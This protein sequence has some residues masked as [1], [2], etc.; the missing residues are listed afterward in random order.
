M[1]R[2]TPLNMPLPG[3]VLCILVLSALFLAIPAANGFPFIFSDTGNYIQS[4]LTGQFR[5]ARSPAYSWFALLAH[6]EVSP[7][8]LVAAQS[9]IV[10]TLNEVGYDG[11]LSVEFCAPIDRTP[12]DP[13]PD[14]LEREPVDISP[15][16]RKFLEE[17]GSTTISETFYSYLVETSAK[18]LL[19]L[20]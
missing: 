10:A 3:K 8:P 9:A 1:L 6:Q 4:A 16:Q 7:W 5:Y 20:I 2:T 11:P 14:A 15:E 19:P 18:T 17:H 13:H 12:A